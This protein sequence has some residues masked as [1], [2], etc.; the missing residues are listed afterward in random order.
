M[1]LIR[2]IVQGDSKAAAELARQ[3]GYQRKPAEVGDWIGSLH[4]PGDSR[5]AF[6]AAEGDEMVG[7]IE[8]SIV[9]HLQS[10]PAGLIGGLVVKEGA[11]SGGI[12]RQLCERAERW[13]AEKGVSVMRV[14]S[15]S[16]REAAHRFYLRDGYRQVKMSCVFEKQLR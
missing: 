1:L 16:T 3:L 5:M 8:V 14:T 12:G 4:Q 2:E 13:A 9:W 7:W 10:D 15:R 11:R 6:V